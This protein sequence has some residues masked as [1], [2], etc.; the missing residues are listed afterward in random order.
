MFGR[1][2]S[3]EHEDVLRMLRLP[4]PLTHTVMSSFTNRKIFMNMLI[5]MKLSSLPLEAQALLLRLLALHSDV[6]LQDDQP[7]DQLLVDFIKTTTTPLSLLPLM[8]CLL[9]KWHA[10]LV[11]AAPPLIPPPVNPPSSKWETLFTAHFRRH[12]I[13][14]KLH[15]RLVAVQ[16]A[17]QQLEETAIASTAELIHSNDLP[18]GSNRLCGNY[19]IPSRSL[20]AMSSGSFGLEVQSPIS[21]SASS[22]R[23]STESISESIYDKHASR[24]ILQHTTDEVTEESPL[25]RIKESSSA[26]L[27]PSSSPYV[28]E[29]AGA[30]TQASSSCIEVL[31][32]TETSSQYLQ[33]ADLGTSFASTAA[34]KDLSAMLLGKQDASR[35]SGG[36]NN[37]KQVAMR[38]SAQIDSALFLVCEPLVKII[39]DSIDL[40]RNNGHILAN[41]CLFYSLAVKSLSLLDPVTVSD[42]IF[43]ELVEVYMSPQHLEEL[44]ATAAS[45]RRGD[46]VVGKREG[47]TWGFLSITF[48]FSAVVQARLRVQLTTSAASRRIMKAVEIC[49]ERMPGQTV[50][51]VLLPCL[52][53]PPALVHSTTEITTGGQEN[54]KTAK[55]AKKHLYELVNRVIRQGLLPSRFVNQLFE[56]LFASS[57]TNR[58]LETDIVDLKWHVLRP[59]T[60]WY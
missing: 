22:K 40:G 28:V 48:F 57:Y 14:N 43:S 25:K 44:N 45:T 19:N 49:C 50:A 6:M 16:E 32:S 35:P 18:L 29:A 60:T 59:I 27:L 54:N 53:P 11:T 34:K 30:S 42:E 36:T 20:D 33:P 2:H 46:T 4:A 8:Q 24:G 39:N 7:V 51:L 15:C 58:D 21:V 47:N 1:A 12:L 17:L 23:K 52:F 41:T 10:H 26:A 13:P 37:A 9:L 56:A 55:T 3:I 38:L 31:T 5:A